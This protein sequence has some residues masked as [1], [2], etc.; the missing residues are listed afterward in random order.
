[1][2]TLQGSPEVW[3]AMIRSIARPSM[4]F[5]ILLSLVSASV[6]C[7]AEIHSVSGNDA[8]AVPSPASTEAPP[9]CPADDEPGDFHCDSC[10]SCPCHAPL[11]AQSLHTDYSPVI[12]HLLALDRLTRLS[13]VFL[14]IFV[15]PQNQA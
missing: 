15:P 5:L 13:E 10:L 6:T 14:P 11:A 4:I 7:G 2:V 9:C 12:S 1:M 3:I 8:S